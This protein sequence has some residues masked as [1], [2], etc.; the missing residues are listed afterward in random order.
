MLTIEGQ[1]NFLRVFWESSKHEG[2][3]V[4]G[5]HQV[6]IVSF[7]ILWKRKPLGETMGT[8]QWSLPHRQGNLVVH[9]AAQPIREGQGFIWAMR[10]SGPWVPAPTVH[11]A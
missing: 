8:A 3:V 5:D 10:P 7:A 4:L 11:Q 6:A 2:P 9:R 1:P